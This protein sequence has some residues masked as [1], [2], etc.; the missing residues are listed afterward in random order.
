MRN[1]FLYGLA[2]ATTFSLAIVSCTPS[3]PTASTSPSAATTSASPSTSPKPTT[4]SATPSASATAKPTASPS[5]SPSASA[6]PSESPKPT[7]SPAADAK[8]DKDAE[9]S[10]DTVRIAVINNSG[11]VLKAIYM[12]APRK[13]DWGDNELDEPLADR[14]KADFEWKRSD[15]KGDDAGCVFDIGAEYSDGTKTV[16]EPIDVC[17]TPAINLK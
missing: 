5:A 9:K 16:L 7:S 3:N 1:S 10:P 17:K 12:S 13:E 6:T 8:P 14:E 2:I 4:A 11:K 15:Y